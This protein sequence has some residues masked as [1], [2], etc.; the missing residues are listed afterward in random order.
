MSGYR[1]L[2]N[3]STTATNS[4]QLGSLSRHV[5]STCLFTNWIV[6]VFQWQTHQDIHVDNR[7]S[8]T[9]SQFLVERYKLRSNSSANISHTNSSEDSTSER[10]KSKSKCLAKSLSSVVTPRRCWLLLDKLF[11]GFQC[12]A[13]PQKMD[14]F[15]C[16]GNLNPHLLL[17]GHRNTKSNLLMV[18]RLYKLSIHYNNN[19]YATLLVDIG[20]RKKPTASIHGLWSHFKRSW[21]ATKMGSVDTNP[22][23]FRRKFLGT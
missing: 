2:L 4:D 22:T 16:G 20:V 15:V 5:V 3:K 8:S 10:L 13:I 7:R 23:K 17:D 14:C 12:L 1:R 19:T 6:F 11:S 21:N 9:E 18:T